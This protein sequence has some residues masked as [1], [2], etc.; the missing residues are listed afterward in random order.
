VQG[1]QGKSESGS[2]HP[3]LGST[4][5]F[6]TIEAI[7]RRLPMGDAV[8]LGPGDDAAVVLAPDGRVVVST[9]VLVD[10]V[11]FRQDWS[12]PD[13]IGHR[14]AAASLADIAAMGA[15]CTSLVVGLAAPADLPL[16]FTLRL[17]DGLRDE[18]AL[19]GASLVGGDVVRSDLLTIAVTALG[20]LCGREPVTRAGA[21][22]GDVVAVCGRLGWAEAGLTVL[23]RGFGSPRA[24]VAAHRR[25]QPPYAAAVAAAV[26]GATSMIDISDGLV[27]DL[28]HVAVASSVQI[29]LD[30]ATLTP[31]AA[32][33]ELASAFGA[34]PLQWVLSGGED[35]AFVATFSA[36]SSLP[37]GF[38]TIGAVRAADQ[39]PDVLVDGSVWTGSSGHEHFGMTTS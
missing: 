21:Q 3:T 34:D 16:A 20:D 17:A 39:E 19:V 32:L 36:G 22:P 7:A 4:G 38:R 5:E 33:V 37:Q 10:G 26:A 24:L 2:P 29:D 27:A 18:A 31:D 8:L 35:H 1:S 14:A 13:D 23:R 15:T 30:T 9:D 6:A 12:A 28:R 25:P 11:H